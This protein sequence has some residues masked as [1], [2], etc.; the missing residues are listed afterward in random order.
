MA[1]DEWSKNSSQEVR[2]RIANPKNVRERIIKIRTEMN[3]TANKHTTQPSILV[4]L[5]KKIE[6]QYQ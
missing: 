4:I 2:K 5:R 1:G 3:E 6:N